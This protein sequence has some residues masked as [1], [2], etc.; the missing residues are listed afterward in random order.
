MQGVLVQE[1]RGVEA[2]WEDGTW[3]AQ[4]PAGIPG[5]KLQELPHKGREILSG[6]A[7]HKVQVVDHCDRGKVAPFN[8]LT[9]CDAR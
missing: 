6:V 5:H 1:E 3:A 4:Q 8:A 9:E 7:Q 2:A